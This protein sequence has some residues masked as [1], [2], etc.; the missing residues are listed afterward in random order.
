MA[1]TTAAAQKPVK[2]G[3]ASVN[4]ILSQMPEAKNIQKQL[5]EY[6]K[7][8]TASLQTQYQEFQ[9]K[10]EDYQKVGNTLLPEIRQQRETELRD[11]QTRIQ[12]S[13]RDAQGLLQKKEGD[14]LEPAYKKIQD[15]IDAVSK[16]QNYTHVL[17]SEVAGVPTLLYVADESNDIS[18]LVLKKMG[19]TPKEAANAQR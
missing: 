3:Y 17:N 11:L 15:N 5:D 18:N 19:I 16:E 4:Y 14:L 2:I 13:E 1:Q 12:Q 6:E 9:K 10:M 8:L 7:Q